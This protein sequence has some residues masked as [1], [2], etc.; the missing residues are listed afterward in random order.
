[1]RIRP[2]SWDEP[3]R[4]DWLRALDAAIAGEDSV[5]V[6]PMG[7][8]NAESGLGEWPEGQEYRARLLENRV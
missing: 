6:G 5:L 3:L 1:M 7:H 4:D 2:S 8:V